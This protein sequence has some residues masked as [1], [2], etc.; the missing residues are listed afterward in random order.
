MQPKKHLAKARSLLSADGAD[1]FYAEISRA[2][3]S[4]VGNKLN[5]AEAG[6]MSREVKEQ[7]EKKDVDQSVIQAYFDCLSVCDRHRFSPSGGDETE[8]QNFLKKAEKAITDLDRQ[9]R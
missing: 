9:I 6:M 2:L 3:S 5:I 7:L 1:A 8:M 4:F